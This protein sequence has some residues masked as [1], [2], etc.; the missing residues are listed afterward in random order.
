[1]PVLSIS[2]HHT[3]S[4]LYKLCRFFHSL[5][6]TLLPFST[7]YAGSFISSPAHSFLSLQ[8]QWL[9]RFFHSLTITLQTWLCR[10]FHSLTITLLPFSTNIMINA[11]SF[12][13]SPSHSFLSLQITMPVL[14]FPHQHTPSF[15]YKHNDYAGSFIP[16]PSHSFLSLQTWLCRFFHSLTITLLPFST[17]IM[18]NAGSFIPSPSHS[19]LSLQT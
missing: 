18:I 19:F 2:H 1:M 4:F 17:N 7:N 15:L 3:P 10:F 16:S 12:I 11:G 9:C 14:S 13:P 8:T 6:I 5:T